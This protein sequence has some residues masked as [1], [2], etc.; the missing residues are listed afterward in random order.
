MA[1][2][3]LEQ[4][5]R[6]RGLENEITVDSAANG[7]PSNSTATNEARQV[8]KEL[9]G[10]D[11]LANHRS[12]PKSE[13]NPGDFYLI[14]TMKEN[15]KHGLPV[16]KTYTLKE[17]AGLKSYIHDPYNRGIERYRECR[18]EIKDCLQRAINRIIGDARPYDK[19]SR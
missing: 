4:M 5:L 3:I 17:Y 12:K 6:E 11:L 1:K 19:G 15:Y 7:I 14:L 10:K 8:I 9:Y 16:H 18:D 2:I 13:I